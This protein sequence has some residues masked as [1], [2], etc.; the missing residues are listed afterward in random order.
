MSWRHTVLQDT[1]DCAVVI[2]RMSAQEEGEDVLLCNLQE[3]KS[4]SLSTGRPG[5][6]NATWGASEVP[7]RYEG[8]IHPL[9]GL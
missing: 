9:V 7:V 8:D 2:K 6:R 3:Q 4:L 5:E 1:V